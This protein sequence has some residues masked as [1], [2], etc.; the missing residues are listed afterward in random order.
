MAVG[1]LC[2]VLACGCGGRRSG[3]S[4]REGT[5]GPPSA[6]RAVDT[7]SAPPTTSASPSTSGA[8]PAVDADAAEVWDAAGIAIARLHDG[9]IRVR[10][11]DR[12]GVRIDTTYADVTYFANAVP[13]LA[14]SV[15]EPQ[16]RAMTELVPRVRAAAA[17][18]AAPPGSVP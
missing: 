5:G 10:G 1:L 17:P 16:A 11:E 9:S 8:D 12:W 13:V 15:T 14:R 7:A 6:T 2:A 4:P 3:D 18:A